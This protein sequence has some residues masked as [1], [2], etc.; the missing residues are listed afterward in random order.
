M[1]PIPA[2]SKE[3]SHLSPIHLLTIPVQQPYLLPNQNH[4]FLV[5]KQLLLR[6]VNLALIYI[7]LSSE[8]LVTLMKVIYNTI[9]FNNYL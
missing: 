8:L 7:T 2:S 4:L 6:P 9:D 1:A 5:L 3:L